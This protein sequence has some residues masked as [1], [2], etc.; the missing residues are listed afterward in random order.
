MFNLE[1]IQ[2]ALQ[3]LGVD[4]W[5][6]YD[7]HGS[8]ILA[9][10]VLAIP[11]DAHT[12]RRFYYF[13]PATG[14]P[15]KLNHRIE[16]DVLE[17]LPGNARLYLQWRQLEEELGQMLEGVGK[18]AMEYSPRN[19]IP[20][21]SKVDAGTVEVVR[22]FG[23][24]VVSS[25]DLI[26]AFE[27]TLTRAQWETHLEAERHM[28]TACG[29]A[30][31]YIAEKVEA[32][33][34]P[35]EAEVQ[36]FIMDYF[37]AN[38]IVTDHAPIVGVGPNSGNPHYAPVPGADREINR[39]DFVL[40]DLWGKMN[41]PGA[42]VAD[43][44]R[45]GFVGSEV[46]QKYTDIFNIVR[47][48]RDASVAL[49]TQ[50]FT[51]NEPVHGWEV[52]DASRNVIEEAGYGQYFIHR[53]GHSIGEE[54]HGNGTH[55]DNLETHDDRRLLRNT[56]FSVEPGIYMEEFGVRSEVDVFI[57]DAGHIHVTGEPQHEIHTLF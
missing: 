12:T 48:A 1:K 6:L 19:G 52:D 36:S 49:V 30:W 47:D 57:D 50:R 7:F 16:T 15:T 43:Y 27:A 3:E 44:T 9:R 21:V 22:S 10:R 34:P 23:C 29:N 54:T 41:Q 28:L 42:V 39:D 20:Y 5:L 53:T 56:C 45:V 55:M 33:T 18:V 8:N 40:I 32:G 51:A 13:I 38:N 11:A 24:E 31:K 25:G 14:Q 17:H 2:S 46:P 4:G 37:K 35:R 26:Q